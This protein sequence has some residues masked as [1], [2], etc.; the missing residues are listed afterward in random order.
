MLCI[1]NLGHWWILLMTEQSQFFFIIHMAQLCLTQTLLQVVL[2]HSLTSLNPSKSSP[3]TQQPVPSPDGFPA[4]LLI[5]CYDILAPAFKLIFS[6][7][8]SQVF[9]PSIL[10]REAVYLFLIRVTILSR[11]ITG[12]SL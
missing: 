10:K 6:Q 1:L 3:L 11:E 7:S 12:Q 9:S 2:S 4:S 8:L 5:K